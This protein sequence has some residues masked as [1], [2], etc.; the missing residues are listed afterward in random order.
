MVRGPSRASALGGPHRSPR[1]VSAR[2]LPGRG[3]A[4]LALLTA[5]CPVIAGPN[6]LGVTGWTNTFYDHQRLTVLA[7]QLVL[8]VILLLLPTVRR[9]A[10]EAWLHLPAWARV[11]IGLFFLLGLFSA[12]SALASGAALLEWGN[13]LTGTG[14][15]LALAG[16]RSRLGQEGDLWLGGLSLAAAIIYAGDFLAFYLQFALD[17]NLRM[18]W[19]S[20]FFH[21]DNV[22]FFNQFQTWSLPLFA[23]AIVIAGPFNRLLQGL[24]LLIGGFW[25]ALLFA[26]GGSGALIAAVI[27]TLLVLL[28]F[29]R[30]SLR[31]VTATLILAALGLLIYLFGFQPHGGAPGPD[32]AISQAGSLDS[33]RIHLWLEAIQVTQEYPLLGIG[34]M[35]LA[36][37]QTANAHPHNLLLQL[38][39]E[40]G[41]PATGAALGL[42][43]GGI[44][45]WGQYWR[46]ASAPMESGPLWPLAIPPAISASLLAGLGYG[47]VSGT[48]VMPTSQAFAILVTG[49]VLGIYQD[50]SRGVPSTGISQGPSQGLI[51]IGATAIGI[52]AMQPGLVATLPELRTAYKAYPQNH[53]HKVYPRY[54]GQGSLCHAPWPPPSGNQVCQMARK[55]AEKYP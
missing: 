11:S 55:S 28:I 48:T 43:L 4:R 1:S 8:F 2:N 20:P 16:S 32:R 50:R 27:S 29:R 5:A 38:S 18:T 24:L 21:F 6:L 31:W 23:G 37:D 12:L 34:P 44:W 10:G 14:I 25:W 41:L 19:D 51:V 52:A 33:G 47:M 36:L 45:A 49:W 22:R 9:D 13:F 3:G 15:V 46:Q 40:W 54:W 26:T 35:Q 30:T 53:G 42:T 39:A 17:P 7:S